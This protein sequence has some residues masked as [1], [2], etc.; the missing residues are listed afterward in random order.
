MCNYLWNPALV[1]NNLTLP[2]L[3]LISCKAFI[4]WFSWGGG[5]GHFDCCLT[6]PEIF[7]DF[8]KMWTQLYF[9]IIW[10]F[11]INLIKYIKDHN[12]STVF[13][14][15]M[16]IFT[17]S[18]ETG[19]DSNYQLMYPTLFFTNMMILTDSGQSIQIWRFSPNVRKQWWSLTS[20]QCTQL[21]SIKPTLPWYPAPR[22][23]SGHLLP[24][25]HVSVVQY[26]I[27]IQTH[28]LSVWMQMTKRQ[29]QG[30]RSSGWLLCCATA[31]STL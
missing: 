12:F 5:V 2:C 22:V 4:S 11:S 10:W 26:V 31:I 28:I 25:W 14:N 6:G 20:N 19:V 8:N 21:Y 23:L 29:L 30:S 13:F 15:N 9:L 1:I 17:K 24:S 16:M 3:N 7:I 18:E 27:Q